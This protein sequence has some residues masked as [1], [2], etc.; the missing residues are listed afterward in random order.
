MSSSTNSKVKDSLVSAIRLDASLT[1][2]A[3]GDP[4]VVQAVATDTAASN[5]VGVYV[6]NWYIFSPS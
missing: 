1:T 2:A 3:R 6:Y 4:T 5:E